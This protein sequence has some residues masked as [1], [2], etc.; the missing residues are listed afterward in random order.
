MR[1]IMFLLL[2]LTGVPFVLR[3]FFQRNRVTILC[4]HDPDPET[5]DRHLRFLAR[6]Y[7]IISLRD[8]V[9]W[10]RGKRR[11]PMP[12]KALVVTF[13]DGHRNNFKLK[14]VFA[15]YNVPATIFVCSGIVGTG[16]HFWWKA[17]LMHAQ[18]QELKRLPDA[19]RLA[20]L[21]EIGFSERQEYSDRQALSIDE[22]HALQS[23]VDFQAHTRFHP[24]L[25]RCDRERAA[26]E[27]AGAQAELE[28]RFGLKIFAIAYPNG[29]YSERDV[30]LVQSAEYLCALTLDAGFNTVDTD[31]FRLRRLAMYDKAG[32]SEVVVKASGF[33]ELLKQTLARK[34]S[35]ILQPP[36]TSATN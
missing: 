12:R 3:E 1:R 13:D 8:Y 4:Y 32:L 18:I 22:M 9:D 31:P 2:R 20:R 23:H 25:P 30:E 11:Q 19:Q 28:S 27:I 7:K 15:K 26:D 33:W 35:G 21:Q 16:R 5:A 14:K 24:V 34:P 36:G 6:H 29:D 10:S 17:G